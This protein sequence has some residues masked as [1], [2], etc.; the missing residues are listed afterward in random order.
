MLSSQEPGDPRHHRLAQV[1]A[2]HVA[3]QRQGEAGLLVPPLAQ[4]DD[5]VQPVI[6]VIELSL[7]DQE[8]GIDLPLPRRPAR[9][10][11]TA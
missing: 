8:A 2:D 7:V 10:G 3:P 1:L 9:S 11:R 4:V 6:A 5:L